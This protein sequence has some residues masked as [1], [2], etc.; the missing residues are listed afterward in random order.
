MRTLIRSHPVQRSSI[1][2]GTAPIVGAPYSATGTTESATTYLDGTRLVQGSTIRRFH[3]DSQGRTRVESSFRPV[4]SPENPVPNSITINDPVAGKQ[5]VLLP[6]QRT[7]NV[8]PWGDAS[9]IRP[10]VPT[11]VPSTRMALPVGLFPEVPES[12][13]M[14]ISLGERLI[15]GIDV[16]GTRVEHSIPAGTFGSQKPITAAVEQWFSP[17]L[18]IVVQTTR[19]SSIGTESLYR[20]EHIVRAEPDAALFSVPAEYRD[21]TA[22]G[23]R[24]PVLQV[25]PA[26]MDPS[27]LPDTGG[28]PVLRTDF[29]D[30]ATW[31]AI[32]DEIQ[33]PS[34]EG[35][36]AGVEFIDDRAYAGMSKER[37]MAAVPE[38]YSH[39][40]IIVVDA[41]AITAK[42]HPV[43]VVSLYKRSGAELRALPVTIQAIENNLS[44]ANLDL[45]DF[46]RGADKTGVFRGF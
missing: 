43:L 26:P 10:P 11:P 12:E 45:E 18:G 30:Q 7:V 22:S 34:P 37:L 27:R 13:C 38:K 16:V 20:L 14:P 35:F 2:G 33:R 44:I 31:E 28:S 23:G 9:A 8:L 46:A 25:V 1:E 21:L 3:R 42:D 41:F 29:S 19:R 4:D 24:K 36:K 15:D 40:F 6:Q 39:T 5:Y 17:D 32:R